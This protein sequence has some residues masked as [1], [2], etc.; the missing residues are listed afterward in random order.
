MHHKYK[1]HTNIMLSK[2]KRG[3]TPMLISH[4]MKEPLLCLFKS[5]RFTHVIL[6]LWWRID[7]A[8]LVGL[9]SL[10]PRVAGLVYL[11][12]WKCNSPSSY[13]IL[14]YYSW[15]K[16][17]SFY[18]YNFTVLYITSFSFYTIFLFVSCSSDTYWSRLTKCNA[19]YNRHTRVL[20]SPL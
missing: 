5:A 4:T 3:Q 9:L 11:E 14:F 1:S 12:C 16:S 7:R 19:T 18:L 17:C 2:S 13:S 8:V 20:I 6:Q 10:A 15:L